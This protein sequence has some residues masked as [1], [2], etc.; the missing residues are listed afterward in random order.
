MIIY[1]RN[2][3]IEKYFKFLLFFSPKVNGLMVQ[4][5]KCLGILLNSFYEA[6]IILIP[7]PDEDITHKKEEANINDEQRCKNPN[8]MLAN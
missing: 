5:L 2:I 4:N 3:L 7:K 6:T 8:K 1:I